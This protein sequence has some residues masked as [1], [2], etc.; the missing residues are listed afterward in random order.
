MYRDDPSNIECQSKA[1]IM[2]ILRCVAAWDKGYLEVQ[3]RLDLL[4]QHFRNRLI[5]SGDDFHGSL[6]LET[7]G[8]DKIIQRVD[9]RDPDAASSGSC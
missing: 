1:I 2:T 7:A 4:S 8:V 5:K 6:R 9:E 3:A